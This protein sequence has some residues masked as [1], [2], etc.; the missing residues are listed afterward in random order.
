M[1]GFRRDLP[2]TAALAFPGVILAA[3]LV[4]GGMHFLAGWSWSGATLFGVLIAATDP[5][6]VIASFREMNVE[7]RLVADQ[8]ALNENVSSPL[9]IGTKRGRQAGMAG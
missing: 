7:R 8:S 3:V 9:A 4:A 6:S 5:V 1:E 2:L